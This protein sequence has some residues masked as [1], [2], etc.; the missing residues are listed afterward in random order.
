MLAPACGKR[1][2]W[3]G[4]SSSR[5]TSEMTERGWAE[6]AKAHGLV[7]WVSDDGRTHE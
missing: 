1:P 6:T 2:S 3:R 5:L 7:P 4:S